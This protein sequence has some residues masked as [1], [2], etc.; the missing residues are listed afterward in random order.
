MSRWR[1][2]F[3]KR[4]AEMVESAGQR[5]LPWQRDVL[6]RI[7]DAGVEAEFR[8]MTVLLNMPPQHPQTRPPVR[9][10]MATHFEIDGESAS[11]TDGD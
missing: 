5:L 3:A 6:Q 7:E 1:P 9:G 10:H 2:G 4:A 8:D 11:G